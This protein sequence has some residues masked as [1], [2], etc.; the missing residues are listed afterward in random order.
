MI[1]RIKAENFRCLRSVDVPLRPFQI[2]V[3]PNGSGKSAFMDVLAFLRTLTA[4]HL[5][6]AVSERTANFHDLVWGRTGN[7]FS[8]SVEAAPPA[9][10]GAPQ[11][12]HIFPVARYHLS[13]RADVVSEVV[14]IEEEEIAVCRAEGDQE[15]AVADHKG[16][17][18]TYF[19]EAGTKPMQVPLDRAHSVLSIA[20]VGETN[21]P[22]AL[23]LKEALSLRDPLG[24]AVCPV[25]LKTE[26]LRAPSPP[27]KGAVKSFTGSHFARLVADLQ[28]KSRESFGQWIE[29]LRTCLPDLETV[30]TVFRPEDRHRYVMVR[31]RNGIEVPSWALSD[32]TLRLM[33]LTVL[34]YLPQSKGIY[35]IEEPENGLHPTAIDA[36]Y[37]SLSSVY[38]GQVL[39]ASHSPILLAAAKPEELLC[40]ARTS[41]EGTEIV[42]GDRHPVLQNWR[43]EVSLGEL[44]AAGVLGQ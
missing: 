30:R 23:W 35:L 34:A 20:P 15:L 26:E 44:F 28:D 10:L 25:A 5:D 29:H 18:A 21:F 36:I 40:F 41:E 14:V 19:Y 27:Y 37:Q 3:G 38:E 2:L 33:A 42:R 16:D 1:T 39:M 11:D 12:G 6:A 31:Y 7:Q 13:V 32:G 4:E 8:L 17:T 9:G 43:G 22:E 24:G